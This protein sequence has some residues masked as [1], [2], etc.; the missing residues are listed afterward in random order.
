[1][2]PAHT[3]RTRNFAPESF[4]QGFAHHIFLIAIRDEP[5]PPVFHQGNSLHSMQVLTTNHGE[6]PP[7]ARTEIALGP[8]PPLPSPHRIFGPAAIR[9]GLMPREITGEI[10]RDSNG[11]LYE[12]LGDYVRPVNQLF[13]DSRGQMIDLAPVRDITNNGMPERHAKENYQNNAGTPNNRVDSVINQADNQM[14]A[15]FTNQNNTTSQA[16]RPF[17]ELARRLI[18]EPGLWR[19]VRYADFL[20]VI[21][22]QLVDPRRLQPGHQ[23][24]CYVQI[25]ELM[26]SH[27]MS[28]LEE[29]ALAELGNAGKL[30][31]LSHDLCR[32]FALNLPRPAIGLATARHTLSPGL[33]PAGSRFITLRVALDP[34]VNPIQQTAAKPLH[35]PSQSTTVAPQIVATV[36]PP[37]NEIHSAKAFIPEAFIKPWELKLSRDEAI[38]DM[39]LQASRN[40]W[41]EMLSRVKNRI[42]NRDIK[43]WQALLQGKSAE[44]Q[45]WEI[46]LPAG[47]IASP[48][49]RRWAEQTLQLAGYDAVKMLVEWEIF[50]RR[51]GL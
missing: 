28:S 20:D 24:A 47:S 38:Y 34:T 40:C 23:L 27:T 25:Y 29:I 19:L 46:K 45:L 21:T 43:K 30:L 18:P 1:M 17:Y 50:W 39:T 4:Q 51:K 31:P 5:D 6:S 8:L 22:P 48:R 9:A 12:K 13:A 32:R 15:E 10:L 49:I 26:T 41:Q 3:F 36:E 14:G 16:V 35:Q 37:V 11:R 42:A 33:A 44:Q 7:I 2:T